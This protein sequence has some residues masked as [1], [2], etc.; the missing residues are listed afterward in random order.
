MIKP[1]QRGRKYTDWTAV[2]SEVD[3]F[4]WPAEEARNAKGRWQPTPR[5][6]HLRRTSDYQVLQHMLYRLEYNGG[7]NMC[8]TRDPKE[9]ELFLVPIYPKQK[10]FIKLLEAYHSISGEEMMR[11]LTHLTKQTVCQHVFVV[12]QV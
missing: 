12:P 1:E 10:R 3:S 11:E 4:G 8:R 5:G 6:V 2:S 7:Q 9:A